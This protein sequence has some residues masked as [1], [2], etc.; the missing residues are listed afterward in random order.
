MTLFNGP[1]Y[2]EDWTI[3]LGQ[4]LKRNDYYW[5]SDDIT[6]EEVSIRVVT[7]AD[8]TALVNLYLNGEIDRVQLKGENIALYKERNDVTFFDSSLMAYITFNLK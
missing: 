3:D 4:T 1:F 2:V 6:L 7:D 8:N 5:E